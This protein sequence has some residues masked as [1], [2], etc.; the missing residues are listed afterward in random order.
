LKRYGPGRDAL[1]LSLDERER[2]R[3]LIPAITMKT[4]P[5]GSHFLC[6]DRPQEFQDLITRFA[7]GHQ[8]ERAAG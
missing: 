2:D 7:G 1:T 4:V 6:L 3:G 8:V 5:D